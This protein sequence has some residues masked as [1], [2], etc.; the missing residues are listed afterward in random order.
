MNIANSNFHGRDRR[1]VRGE[2]GRYENSDCMA[3]EKR[4]IN[5]CDTVE[6]ETHKAHPIRRRGASG[7]TREQGRSTGKPKRWRYGRKKVGRQQDPSVQTTLLR[8]A[9]RRS[10]HAPRYDAIQCK[11]LRLAG[12]HIALGRPRPKAY[13]SHLAPSRIL[14][15]AQIM[16]SRLEKWHGDRSERERE[17]DRI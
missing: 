5:P 2:A 4:S 16:P 8:Y 11:V 10:V 14:H 13:I 15:I 6:Q 1:G 7:P 12:L 17:R 3:N 9:V